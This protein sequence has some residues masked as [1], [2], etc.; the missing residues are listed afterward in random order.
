MTIPED[1]QEVYASRFGVVMYDTLEIRHNTFEPLYL[2]AGFENITATLEDESTQ[3]LFTAAL[4]DVNLPRVEAGEVS[5]DAVDRALFELID[6]AASS[7]L[8][9]PVEVTYRTYIDSDLTV[10]Q[11]VRK[12]YV[13]NVSADIRKIV[14]TLEGPR[15]QNRKFPNVEYGRLFAS[16]YY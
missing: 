15:F 6:E 9:V 3:Q 12:Y 4:M 10:P 16:L 1:L 7:T 14:L 5:L 11:F 13:S 8:E 2:V